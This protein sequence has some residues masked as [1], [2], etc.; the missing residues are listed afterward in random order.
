MWD[1][2]TLFVNDIRLSLRRLIRAP[3]FALIAI[4]TLALGIG[5]N[6]SI[7]SVVDAALIRALP[8]P[9]ANQIVRV[10]S[11]STKGPSS[12]SPPDFVD[13]RASGT[14]SSEWPQY[15][16]ART[17]SRW[18]HDRRR[19]RQYARETGPHGAR[20]AH[21]LFRPR[22]IAGRIFERRRRH[23][24]A[25]GRA[26][27]RRGHGARPGRSGLSSGHAGAIGR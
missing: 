20:P 26:D 17:R 24:I 2:V 14:A 9:D 25:C 12:V 22:A 8:Y 13:W 3:G 5:A 18:W 23:D 6:A 15:R 7:F 11:P 4:L 10:Y 16:L 21:D 27:S 1:A 19:R